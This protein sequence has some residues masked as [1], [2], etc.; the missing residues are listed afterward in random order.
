[1]KKLKLWKILVPTHTNDNQEID[2]EYHKKWDEFVQKL[3]N[4]L[5]IQKTSKGI[6]VN[7]DAIKYEEQMIPVEIVC[8]K[9][10]IKKISNFSAKHYEQEAIMFSLISK[11]VHIVNYDTNFK[12]IKKE[13]S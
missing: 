1:M 7:P 3:T 2:I 5:T 8:T 11:E 6:W 4:G 9:K 13:T 10:Q 12:R